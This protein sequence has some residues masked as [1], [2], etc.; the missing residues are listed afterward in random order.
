MQQ[1]TVTMPALLAPIADKINNALSAGSLGAVV[2]RAGVGKTSFLV[3]SA[4][5]AMLNGKNVLHINLSDSVKKTALWYNEV[6]SLMKTHGDEQ[7]G[8]LSLS[9][10]LSRRLI[11]TMK[12]TG[13]SVDGVRERLM[14]FVE[15]N[16]FSPQLIVLDG[17]SVDASRRETIAAL[18]GLSRELSLST[19]LSVP[20]HREEERDDRQ[21][22][23]GFSA[24]ADLFDVAWEL[25]PESKKIRVR[26]LP[27]GEGA[28]SDPGLFLNPSTMLLDIE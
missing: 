13:F 25:L 4:L 20:A 14:D 12:A 11:M 17:F 19:W 7:G 24:V 18:K 5:Y 9:P 27:T 3:Q 23:A 8:G 6:L 10:L 28:V 1:Q 26:S 16:V 22:P 21:R 15:Q 2:A